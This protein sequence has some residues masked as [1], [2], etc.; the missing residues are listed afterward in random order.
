MA[1]YIDKLRLMDAMAD[2][3]ITHIDSDEAFRARFG[4]SCD[5]ILGRMTRSLIP[6]R[7]LFDITR[8]CA[9]AAQR[10]RGR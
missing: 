6:R 10:S 4:H 5:V 7:T 8:R 3:E 2:G 9:S 1:V